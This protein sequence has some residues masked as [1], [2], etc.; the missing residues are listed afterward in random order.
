VEEELD[1]CSKS[2]GCSALGTGEGGCSGYIVSW[3]DSWL[4]SSGEQDELPDAPLSEPA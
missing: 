1:S 4:L 3:P 2:T